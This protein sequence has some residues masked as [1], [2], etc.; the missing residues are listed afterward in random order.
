MPGHPFVSMRHQ[1]AYCRGRDTKVGNLVALDHC[2]Y[3]IGLG[4]IGGTVVHKE[5]CAQ[6]QSAA[7]SPRAHHPSD[8][9][10]PEE[11]VARLNVEAMGH[12]LNAFYGEAAVYMLRALGL[13]CGAGRVDNHIK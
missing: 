7:D 2:P 11:D 10:V 4:E 5:S 12:V 13:S 6:H 9:G 3:A 1:S 8:I